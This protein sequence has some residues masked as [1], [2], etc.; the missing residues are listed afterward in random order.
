MED[1][2]N[3]MSDP[4]GC[5]HCLGR[6]VI[7]GSDDV[8]VR[9]ACMDIQQMTNRV[10]SARLSRELMKCCFEDFNFSYYEKD[11]GGGKEELL[12][13]RKA[14]Q[15]ARDFVDG[16][17][18]DPHHIGLLYTGQAGAGKT[19][20]AAAIANELI[21]QNRGVLFVVV[22]DL[23]DELRATYDRKDKDV[24][25]YDILDM[26]KTVPV[27]ILDDLGS[28]NYTDWTRNRIYS[29]LNHRVNE[30]LPVIVTTNLHPL[31]INQH[32]GERT[33]SRLVQMCRMFKLSVPQDIRWQQY[34]AREKHE[35]R[36]KK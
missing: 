34:Y 9:C 6:G 25:E 15:A 14:W 27:L 19:Y 13:A 8:A 5:P 35:R 4:K 33:S 7:V 36:E 10:R 21:R 32:L 23:L 31:E 12:G 30:K 24:S 1:L 20:L 16:V 2:K 17:L 29:I 3:I 18:R 28:H 11:A 22:P 26:A